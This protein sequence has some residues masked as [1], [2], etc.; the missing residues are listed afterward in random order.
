MPAVRVRG[1][2][3][4]V[5]HAGRHRKAWVFGPGMRSGKVKWQVAGA[6]RSVEGDNKCS[7]SPH[8]W[9]GGGRQ[10]RFPLPPRGAA[11]P[12]LRATSESWPSPCFKRIS[13]RDRLGKVAIHSDDTPAGARVHA[14]PQGRQAPRALPVAAARCQL[15]AARAGGFGHQMQRG[16]RSGRGQPQRGSNRALPAGARA[17]PGAACPAHAGTRLRPCGRPARA[18]TSPCKLSARLPP[19]RNRPHGD[20]AASARQQPRR[21]PA[22][23]GANPAAGARRA[24]HSP[25][26][27]TPCCA[28]AAR[29][30]VI[31]RA[32]AGPARSRNFHQF[33]G[34]HRPWPH[35][36]FGPCRPTHHT[37]T[38]P[39]YG[40]LFPRLVRFT[41][42]KRNPKEYTILT[43]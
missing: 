22:G 3:P 27:L 8:C 25:R 15:V 4:R 5:T 40:K 18:T 14:R 17:A 39:R 23:D 19:C 13:P 1:V 37:S 24:H 26:T 41:S 21:A 2:F 10:A 12:L 38:L 32:V 33:K 6:V 34:T 31:R 9:R 36:V 28:S 35:H 42:K 11:A 43:H 30:V 29:I 16:N 7:W 20:R